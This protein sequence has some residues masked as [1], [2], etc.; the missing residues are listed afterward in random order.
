MKN[1]APTNPAPAAEE[2][3]ERKKMK[4]EKEEVHED[5]KEEM[6][7]SAQSPSE[8]EVEEEE[9]EEEE[10]SE[11]TESDSGS[12]NVMFIFEPIH[13]KTCFAICEQ[14]SRRSACACTQ[15]DMRLLFTT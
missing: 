6:P 8:E 9:E 15:S 11:D 14:Q 12:G 13:E 4:V 3:P 2:V 10:E 5:V 7:D 1:K